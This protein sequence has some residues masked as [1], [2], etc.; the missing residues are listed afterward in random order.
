MK[1]GSLATS[2]NNDGLASMPGSY[3]A[4][5]Y[6]G[7]CATA[8]E[9]SAYLAMITPAEPATTYNWSVDESV[10]PSEEPDSVL[11]APAEETRPEDLV[12]S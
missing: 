2:E 8:E 9:R 5:S 1:D 4:M 6:L 11:D 10:E 12:T 7:A 3:F